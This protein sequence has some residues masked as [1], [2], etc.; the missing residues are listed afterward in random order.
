MFELHR[1]GRSVLAGIA[2]AATVIV[3]APGSASAGPQDD[4]EAPATRFTSDYSAIKDSYIVVL[5]DSAT[6][7]DARVKTLAVTYGGTVTHTYRSAVRGFAV[8]MSAA[9]AG[10]L[11]GS[12][13]VASVEQNRRVSADAD[14]TQLNVPSWGLDRVD[15][16][17]APMNKRF[18]YPNT[19]S[20][21]RAYVIDSGVRISHAEFGGRASHG[22]DFVDNDRVADDCAGHGTHVAGIIGG[23]NYGVA[24]EVRLVSV[25]VLDCAN[26]SDNATVIAGIDWVTANAVKPAVVNMS[27]GGDVSAAIDAAVERSIASGL[28]YAVSAGNNH[29]DACEKSPA[30]APNAI[31]V[32]ATDE[33]DFRA[34]FSNW[35]AAWT[36]SRPA[37]AF[38]R[39]SGAATPRSGT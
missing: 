26:L 4:R 38:R 21:V 22:Y 23:T 11:A 7:V 24:K 32:G 39:R 29:L 37:T 30:H 6:P 9:Q 17:F 2:V 31:T 16:I 35:E 19:A 34:S 12:P 33:V 10:K 18:T 20:N 3:A 27:L 5:K 25:R 28:T 1:A 8:T 15:Q 13:E 14:A 36:S